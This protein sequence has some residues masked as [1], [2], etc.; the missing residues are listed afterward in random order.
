M[1]KT[2]AIV[3]VIF[4]GL[5]TAAATPFSALSLAWQAGSC[6]ARERRPCVRIRTVLRRLAPVLAA[7]WLAACNLAAQP[8]E[9]PVTAV[10]PPSLV[11]DQ[12]RLYF[13]RPK[14]SLF[15]AIRPGVIINNRK[16]GVSVVGEAFYRDAQPGRYEIFLTSD[17]MDRLT[18]TLAPGE[19][20][21]VRTSISMSWL[22]PQLSPTPVEADQGERELRDLVLVEPR[23][24]D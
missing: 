12:A 18:V 14:G 21:Y 13:Y 19:V 5:R 8:T 2:D 11:A 3:A 20:R 24:E 10:P 6:R 4:Y 17:D 9:P 16:V 22:G 15:P 23:L 1:Q 7:G